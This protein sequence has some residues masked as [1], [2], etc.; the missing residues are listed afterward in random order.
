ML[1]SIGE[2]DLQCAHNLDHWIKFDGMVFPVEYDKKWQNYVK[3]N[4][5]LDEMLVYSQDFDYKC[6]YIARAKDFKE[7]N[8]FKSKD[9][10]KV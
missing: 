4:T 5:H 6:V 1:E 3:L 10:S 9:T 2:V 8:E 7:F